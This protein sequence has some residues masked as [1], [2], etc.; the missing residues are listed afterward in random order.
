MIVIFATD[1]VRLAQSFGEDAT[2][3]SNFLPRIVN[4][5]PLRFRKRFTYVAFLRI[6]PLLRG[7]ARGLLFVCAGNCLVTLVGAERC[8]PAILPCERDSDLR[9]RIVNFLYQRHIP[10]L[11]SIQVDVDQG[12]VT[13]KGK[14]D[15]FYHKQL[16]LNCCQRVAGVVRLVDQINVN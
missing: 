10:S 7:M 2:R 12:V 14:V 11:R 4:F 5:P 9:R 3:L 13:M 16:C 8:M 15:S 6:L 1:L